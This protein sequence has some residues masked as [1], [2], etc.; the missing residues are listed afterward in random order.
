VRDAAEQRADA[1]RSKQHNEPRAQGAVP[2]SPPLQ[3]AGKQRA[4][5]RQAEIRQ[6]HIR[7]DQVTGG[8]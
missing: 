5:G 2:Q 4:L 3:L 1:E 7:L 8:S 6:G